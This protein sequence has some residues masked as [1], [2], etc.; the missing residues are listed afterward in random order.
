MKRKINIRTIALVLLGLMC[1][2]DAFSQVAT[3]EILRVRQL[4]GQSK[5][6]NK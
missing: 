1:G 5:S 2:Q 6:H 4:V 3:E